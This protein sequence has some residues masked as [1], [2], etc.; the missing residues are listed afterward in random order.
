MEKYKAVDVANWMLN[1]QS[2][3]PKKLQKMVY[4]VYAWTLTLLN[5][6]S[7]KLNNRLF[8]EP[9]EAW[10]H[11]PVVPSLYHKYS[12]YGYDNIDKVDHCIKFPEDVEDVL[13]QVLDVYG[14]YNA[15]QLESITHQESPWI[16]AR[17]GLLPLEGGNRPI[18]DK[19]IFDYYI[20]QSA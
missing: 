10:V 17:Q 16:N 2:M 18:K 9:I 19:D 4:Y 20:Q 13:N 5:E 15:N 7:D 12:Q 11:G 6:S 3:S 1:K 14:S 8:D